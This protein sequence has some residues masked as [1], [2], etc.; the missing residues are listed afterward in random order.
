MVTPGYVHVVRN[1]CSLAGV[2]VQYHAVSG[3]YDVCGLW[4]NRPFICGRLFRD[5]SVSDLA[6]PSHP[7]GWKM[8]SVLGGL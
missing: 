8:Q 5:R 2:S 6:A 4:P 3:R 7:W 1:W